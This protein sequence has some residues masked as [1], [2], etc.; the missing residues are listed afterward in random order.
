MISVS[1]DLDDDAIVLE[2]GG[3]GQLVH[4]A[5]LVHSDGMH[6]Q[7]R[8]HAGPN[9]GAAAILLTLCTSCS[10]PPAS[11]PASATS[12]DQWPAYAGPSGAR[13][14]P[15]GQLT[16]AN[17]SRLAVAWTYHT[18]ETGRNARDGGKL[19]FEA[20]PLHFDGRLYLATAYG[21]IIALDPQTGAEIW[22]YDA[23]VDRSV[24][25]SE[26]TSRGV[27]AWRAPD[28]TGATDDA[29]CSRRII[30]GTIDARLIALDAVTGTPCAD[31]GTNGTV[32]LHDGLDVRSPPDY[33]VTSPPAII[34]NL[35]VVGSSIGD[36]W[37]A[38]TGNGV[39]RAFDVRTGAERWRWNPVPHQ[40][41]VTGAAN[42]WSVI[43]V[44]AARDLL[45]V[46]TSSPS[47]DFYGGLRPGDN[48]FANS[49]VALRGSTGEVVWS[50]QTVHHD[51]WDYDIAAQ[52]VLVDVTRDGRTIAA[53]AQPTKTGWL[54]VL[55]RATGE[56]LF[57][58]QEKP[59]PPSDIE[60]ER[61]W[62]TQP[63]SVGLPVL[64]PHGPLTPDTV[65]GPTDEAR[66]ECRRLAAP[67]KSEGIYTPPSL[68]GTIMSPGNGAGTNWGSAAFAP[69]GQRLV[70]NTSRI[71][72]LV[73]LIP[74][75][76]FDAA[77]AEGGNWEFGA[78]REAPFGMRRKTFETSDGIP[79]SPPPWGTLA[80]VDLDTGDLAWEVPLGHLPDGHPMMALA[81]PPPIGLPN[82][83]GPIVTAGGLVFIGATLDQRLRAFDLAS[84]TEAWQARLPFAAI[85]TPMTYLASDGRQ[86]VV[87]AAG[88][89]GKAGLAIGDAVVAFALPR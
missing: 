38:D 51:L 69:A 34:D 15:A 60:G 89:H 47:P 5:F 4:S 33:Q 50:F 43:N 74:R 76:R 44:D 46:P 9:L 3:R 11:P 26:V 81:G 78:Q 17:V 35:I 57:E 27:S 41:G 87:I 29:P 72:T 66:A 39:V 2:S 61:A 73:Q 16:P 12:P 25:Y 23:A 10:A 62:P 49:I 20:T 54:F 71:A 19:T 6:E 67:L 55:D 56:P 75:D 65:W 45:F 14:A 28:T 7:T 88:G 30:A 83:G 24:S 63:A 84:G 53:V 86:F 77:R 58:V 48:A 42:A 82:S 52:P 36:N 37:H 64:M 80:A 1:L 13:Y 22:T 85:A 18:G 32:R 68:Q 79:C 70:L 8:R 40:P 31:F 21:R 59:V